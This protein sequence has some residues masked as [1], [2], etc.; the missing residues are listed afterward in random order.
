[1][2]KRLSYAAMVLVGAIAVATNIKPVAYLQAIV[3]FSGTGAAATF[4]VPVLM[5]AFWRRATVAGAL[6]AMFAGAATVLGLYMIGFIGLDDPKYYANGIV[7]AIFS[8]GNVNIGNVTSFRPHFLL[9][10]DPVVWGL[11]VSLIAGI[12]VSKATR[13][14]DPETVSKYF[15]AQT[16][17]SSR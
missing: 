5:L 17:D 4:V 1:E 2:L 7:P 10:I 16:S 11:L 12:V 15:D 8:Y 3:V 9:E 6:A 13:P 14:V